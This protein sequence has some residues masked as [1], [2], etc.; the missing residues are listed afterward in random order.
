MRAPGPCDVWNAARLTPEQQTQGSRYPLICVIADLVLV[1]NP[2]VLT[3]VI[4]HAVV[5]AR[6]CA[7]VAPH[8]SCQYAI[9][10]E[11]HPR[12]LFGGHFDGYARHPSAQTRHRRGALAVVVSPPGRGMRREGARERGWQREW[13]GNRHL[14]RTRP[15]EFGV[16]SMRY[17]TSARV[18]SR[19]GVASPH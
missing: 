15:R 8:A 1:G 18:G 19:R 4:P 17:P 14:A 7:S 12:T 5:V 3:D 9:I 16:M 13:V 2:P 11:G 6:V 10:C